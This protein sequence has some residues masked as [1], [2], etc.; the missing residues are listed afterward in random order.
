MKKEE[1]GTEVFFKASGIPMKNLSHVYRAHKFRASKRLFQSGM[2]ITL[3]SENRAVLRRHNSD[4]VRSRG[5]R[6]N[7]H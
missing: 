2:G 4:F 6:E 1:A 7:G 5:K 3:V